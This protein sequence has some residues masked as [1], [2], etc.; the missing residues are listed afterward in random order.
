MYPGFAAYGGD[1]R[2]GMAA[3]S[4]E[5]GAVELARD[6]VDEL[7]KSLSGR[8][9]VPGDAQYDSGRR[10]WNSIHDKKP[11]II[12]QAV[13]AEDLRKAVDFAREHRLLVAVKG[14]GHSWPGKSVCDGGLMLD[15]GPINRVTVDRDTRVAAAGGGARIGNLDAATLKQGLVT[16]GGVVSHTGIGGYTLGGGFGRLNRKYGLAIDNLLGAD[17][18]TADGSL[19][20]TSAIDEPDL[21]W[22]IRGGGGNFGV[23]T[24]FRFA[25]HEFDR[26]L[27]SGMIRWP[28]AQ[29]RQVLRFYADWYQTLTNNLYVAPTMGTLSDYTSFVGFDVLYVGNA[30]AGEKELAPLRTLGSPIVDDIRVQDYL[31]MQQ[32]EDADL[33]YGIRSYAK[34]GMA[35]VFSYELADA[36][37]DTFRPDPRLAFFSHTAGGKIREVAETATAFPHRRQDLMLG[38]VG[39][40]SDPDDD[41]LAIEILREWYGAIEPFTRGHYDNIEYDGTSKDARGYG[42]N[43]PRLRCVKAQYDRENLFR[44]NNNIEPDETGRPPETAD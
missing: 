13:T 36:L 37:I 21:F 12:V 40:W 39:A 6:A 35:P 3:V 14:G 4:L 18:V 9:L 15:V 2:S 32:R 31:V 1:A 7:S 10:I 27:L 17:I 5:G 11:A 8:L 26:N 30:D 24:Q 28:V 22:A 34:N 38:V 23:V 19:R 43:Y 16:T 44:L 41:E 42:L 20:R 33:A 25:L 29:S